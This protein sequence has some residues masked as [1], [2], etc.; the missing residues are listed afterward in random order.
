VKRTFG[1]AAAALLVAGVGQAAPFI[2]T[3][4][5]SGLNE[6][7]ATTS[8]GTGF[9]LM[10]L[11]TTAQTLEVNV[12][13]SNLLATTVTGAPSGT[14]AS[15]IHCCV[16]PPDNAGVATTTPTFAGFPLGVDSGSFD[17]ILDLTSASSYN[18]AFVTAQGGLTAAETALVN[19]LLAGQTYLNIH[20][21]AFPGGEI[22][23]FLTPTPEPTTMAL[24]LSA[25]AVLWLV[26]RRV[27]C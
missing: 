6:N 3:G 18:P 19:G 12:V 5:L 20:T 26:R 2:L 15:H 4:T 24:A 9:A 17:R 16:S 1:L 13:F 21:N 22:R 10:T 11:D 8:A 23:A 14:T 25:L 7:P 27:Q